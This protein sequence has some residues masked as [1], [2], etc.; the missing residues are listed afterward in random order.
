MKKNL[1]NEKQVL[2]RLDISDFS[3]MT[4][5]K[6]PLFASILPDMDP[7]IAKKALEQFPDF[8]KMATNLVSEYSSVVKKA[9]EE[10]TAST[11]VY[12]DSCAKV[13]DSLQK[14][15]DKKFLLPKRREKIIDK[16][17]EVANMIDRKDSEH[18]NFILKLVSGVGAVGI[19]VAGLAAYI[20]TS[21]KVKIGKK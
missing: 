4:E 20:V 19:T 15:L 14:E 5:D 13:L 9:M 2:K 18:K 16:M 11:K 6:A 21:G 8:S 17:I 10:G 7:E 3:Q 12:Y 1:L